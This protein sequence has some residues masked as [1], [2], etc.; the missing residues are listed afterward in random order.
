M[1]HDARRRDAVD[2]DAI[3]GDGQEAEVGEEE[4]ELEAE[5]AGDVAVGGL[6]CWSLLLGIGSLGGH[7]QG[8]ADVL[9]LW[10]VMLVAVFLE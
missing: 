7:A 8:G 6:V 9:E 4:S 1:E 5:D 2:G 10:G 3:G